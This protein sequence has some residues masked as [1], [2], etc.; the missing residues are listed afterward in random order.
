M[1]SCCLKIRGWGGGGG[2]SLDTPLSLLV[3]RGADSQVGGAERA[4][5]Q[6]PQAPPWLPPLFKSEYS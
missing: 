4:G 2:R 1:Q 5:V 3:A 6:A